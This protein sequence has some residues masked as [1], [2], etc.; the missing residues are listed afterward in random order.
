MTAS[1]GGQLS[2]MPATHMAFAWIEL[3]STNAALQR[4]LI[5]NVSAKYNESQ[6]NSASVPLIERCLNW[7]LQEVF[8]N[9]GQVSYSS[10]AERVRAAAGAMSTM[11][12]FLPSFAAHHQSS[13]TDTL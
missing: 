5:C 11:G 1:E 9:R 6:Q 7:G 4:N 8:I 12:H 3:T 13:F 10:Q 2:P